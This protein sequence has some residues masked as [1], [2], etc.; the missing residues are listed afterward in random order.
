MPARSAMRPITPSIASISRTIWPLPKPPIAGLQ[1]IVP[2]SAIR[3]V[4]KAVRAPMRAAAAAASHPACP[5]PITMTS[6]C[7]TWNTPTSRYRNSR[8]SPREHLQR[9]SCRSAYPKTCLPREEIRRPAQRGYHTRSASRVRLSKNRPHSSR[10]ASAAPVSEAIRHRNDRS[11]WS[12][13]TRPVCPT[14]ARFDLTQT[15]RLYRH[16]DLPYQE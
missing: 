2:M 12:Q 14:L 5:A 8:I 10:Q 4:T 3:N 15:E 6:K 7:F 9:R 13:S 1:D 16:A 11:D